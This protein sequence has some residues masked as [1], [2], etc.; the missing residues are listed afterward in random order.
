MTRNGVFGASLI[1][2]GRVDIVDKCR[3]ERGGHAYA[4]WEHGGKA[5]SP[6]AMQSFAPPRKKADAKT[7]YGCRVVHHECRLLL[8]RQFGTQVDGLLMKSGFERLLR[9]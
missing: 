5:V 9:Q 7:R 3:I 8:Y 2:D 6:D 1:G 4:L